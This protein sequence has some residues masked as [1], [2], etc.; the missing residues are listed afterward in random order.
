MSIVIN[1]FK[2]SASCESP[3]AKGLHS[4]IEL[5]EMKI[6]LKLVQGVRL[7]G[8]GVLFGFVVEFVLSYSKL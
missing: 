8:I 3:P 7:K 2:W 4:L 5:H 6:I 1:A